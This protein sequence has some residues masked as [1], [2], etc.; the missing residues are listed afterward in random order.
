LL[1]HVFIF[2]FL[3]IFFTVGFL[4]MNANVFGL[5]EGWG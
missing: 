1:I 2:Q 3:F 5:C 4:P